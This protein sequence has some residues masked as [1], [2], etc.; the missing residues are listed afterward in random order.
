MLY[1]EKRIVLIFTLIATFFSFYKL[2]AYDLWY[3]EAV[4]FF[5]AKYLKFPSFLCL[6]HLYYWILHLFIKIRG[7]EFFI[8]LP[9]AIFGTAVVPLFYLLV[10][11]LTDITTAVISTLF[12]VL[13]PLRIWYSQEGTIH[14]FALFA[15]VLSSYSFILLIQRA[16]FKRALFLFIANLLALFASYYLFLLITMQ[17]LFL[18]I[19]RKRF[20]QKTLRYFFLI[21]LGVLTA[22]SLHWV[23]LF[24]SLRFLKGGF[25]I[26]EVSWVNLKYSIENFILGYNGTP[27][28]YNIAFLLFIV[29]LGV[30]IWKKKIDLD[31]GFGIIFGLFPLL[32]IWILHKIFIPVY[33]DRHN[34][35]F[36]PP[37][38]LLLGLSCTVLKNKFS[39]WLLTFGYLFLIGSG[40]FFYERDLIFTPLDHHLGVYERKNIRPVIE[41]IK[42]RSVEGDVV[43]HTNPVTRVPF[44]YYWPE[45]PQFFLISKL[46]PY[47]DR[48]SKIL[49]TDNSLKL[50]N[51]VINI[52][53]PKCSKRLGKRIWIVA[54]TWARDGK[55]DE[56]GEEAMDKLREM[57]YRCVMVKKINGVVVGLFDKE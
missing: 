2:T 36:M 26:P 13:S 35:V 55:I 40:L 33:L 8:R 15:S 21:S 34:M 18:I 48:I 54:A 56:N 32:I 17:F 38:Y 45:R 5:M 53:E 10:R 39:K 52:G 3:D 12:F 41:F 24:N 23:S 50:S 20:H 11:R 44:R 25:W 57:G 31:I 29:S 1:L 37:L 49:S 46:D 28:F 14:I 7:G 42:N 6:P 22:Y 16:N 30:L 19:F 43:V 4:N 51:V 27:L 47:W 9:S